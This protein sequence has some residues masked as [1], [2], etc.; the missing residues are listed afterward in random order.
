LKKEIIKAERDRIVKDI[1][2]S[3]R[4]DTIKR[5]EEMVKRVQADPF[6]DSDDIIDGYTMCKSK[7]LDLLSTPP[8]INQNI[9]N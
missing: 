4:K 1:S 5:V 2:E 9:S 3:I 7:I 6:K 8:L